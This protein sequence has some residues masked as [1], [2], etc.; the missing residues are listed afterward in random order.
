MNIAAAVVTVGMCADDCLM[1]RKVFFAEFLAKALRQIY[2]QSMIGNI[3][4]IKA[5]N[6]V[7]AFDIFTL[8]IF[9]VTEVGSQTRNRKIF[10][11]AVQR[12]NAVILSWD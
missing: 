3:L 1:T 5:D 2:V 4:G 7:M 6:I 8:L 9:A 12:G 10:V 11:T